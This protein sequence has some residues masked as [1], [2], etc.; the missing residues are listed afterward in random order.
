MDL[1]IGLGDSLGTTKCNIAIGVAL[2]LV[3]G[4][5]EVTIQRR[6]QF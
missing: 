5:I 2:G 6:R 1:E 3:I 4:G